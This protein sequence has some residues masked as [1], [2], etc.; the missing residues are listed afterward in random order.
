MKRFVSENLMRSFGLPHTIVTDNRTQ[1][2][3]E[4]F[5]GWCEKYKIKQVLILVAHPQ[6][7]RLVERANDNI[8]YGIKNRLGGSQNPWVD[9][10]PHVL[11]AFRTTHKSA[12]WETHSV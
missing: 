10:L 11:W 5:W 4:P 8:V 6:A 9:E 1:F 3:K 2:E 7:N 12:N